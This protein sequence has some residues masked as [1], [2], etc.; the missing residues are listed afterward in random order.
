MGLD[1]GGD[2]PQSVALAALAEITAVFNGRQ[3]GQ[4]KHRFGT[5][6]G[7]NDGEGVLLDVDYPAAMHPRF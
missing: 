1:L 5:I 7:R 3:G 6:H 4:L 2:T